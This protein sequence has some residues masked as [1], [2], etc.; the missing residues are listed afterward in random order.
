MSLKIFL[1]INHF[2]NFHLHLLFV[3]VL[4]TIFLIVIQTFLLKIIFVRLKYMGQQYLSYFG[5]LNLF[6]DRELT[7]H[8]TECFDFIFTFSFSFILLY[9][10][11]FT[12]HF[13]FWIFSLISSFIFN[14][15]FSYFNLKITSSLINFINDFLNQCHFTYNF[16]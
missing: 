5:L 15:N 3:E 12:K 8:I 13:I 14:F 9:Q 10:L 16:T 7:F 11:I 6:K 4:V 2:L 1:K